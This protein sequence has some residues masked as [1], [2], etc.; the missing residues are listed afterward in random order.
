MN[1][2][3]HN[4]HY[5]GIYKQPADPRAAEINKINKIASEVTKRAIIKEAPI[6][7]MGSSKQN[8]IKTAQVAANHAGYQG[9]GDTVEQAPQVYSPLWLNSNLSLP[10]DRQTINAWCRQFFALN[11]FVQNAIALHSTYPISKLNIKC[12]NKKAENFYNE[13]IEAT[14]L[15]NVCMQIAQQYYLL[16]EAFV[17]NEFNGQ[18]WT[19]FILQNP[20]YIQIQPSLDGNPKISMMPDEH[21][22][23]VCTSND[24]KYVEERR[25]YDPYIVECV[26][27]GGSVPLDKFNISHICRRNNPQ[28]SRGT[29]LVVSIFRQLALFDQFREC[30]YYQAANM[31]NP[32]TLVQ[33][34]SGEYRPS[35]DVLEQHRQIWEA[36]QNN[37]DFKIFTTDAIKVDKIGSGGAIYDTSGKITQLIKEIYIGLQVPSAIMDGG[38]DTTYANA[39]VAL[40]V[41]KDRYIFFRNLLAKWLRTKVFLPLAIIHGFYDIKDGKKHYHIPEID[42]NHMSL[43][44]TNEYVQNLISLS[45]DGEDKKASIKSLYRSLGMD[46]ATERRN[47][48]REAIDKQILMKEKEA[49]AKMDLNELR[50]ITDD[51][52]IKMPVNED[53]I[54]E[55]NGG[56][57]GEGGG[58]LP[59]MPGLP[60]ESGSGGLDLGGLGGPP[61]NGGGGESAP[62]PELPPPA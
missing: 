40:D 25:K 56:A 33:V 36:A 34:G 30:D 57:G 61:D 50:S 46:Y 54:E 7:A 18:T 45:N 62:M 12:E 22:K 14:D 26:R 2:S 10:R 20:D 59:G 27:R 37:Q 38:A 13:L 52:E 31:V 11:P 53:G 19:R 9:A 39:G 60:G 1:D 24:P 21:L 49:L 51:D 3:P 15:E 29:G 47:I 32:I 16:G 41:V 5:K 6:T 23:K 35:P 42:W 48:R 58:D 17:Y 43:F 4:K 55:N 28:D 8:L 44:D